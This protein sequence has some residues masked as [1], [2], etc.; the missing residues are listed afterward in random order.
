MS[1]VNT[2]AIPLP[3]VDFVERIEWSDYVYS[4]HSSHDFLPEATGIFLIPQSL[5]IKDRFVPEALSAVLRSNRNQ[6]GTFKDSLLPEMLGRSSLWKTLLNGKIH[7]SDDYEVLFD[8]HINRYLRLRKGY[9]E[10]ASATLDEA[11]PDIAKEFEHGIL[12]GQFRGYI[13][14]YVDKANVL[15]TV[16]TVAIQIVDSTILNKHH[17]RVVAGDYSGNSDTIH[18]GSDHPDYTRILVHEFRHRLSG[19]TFIKTDDP[20]E[21]EIVIRRTRIGFQE[22][23]RHRG[24]DEALVEHTTQA[25]IEGDWHTLDPRDRVNDNKVYFLERIFT[26]EFI[27][28]SGGLVSLKT[29]MR[30]NFED[31]SSTGGVKER[32]QMMR[33]CRSAY[34]PGALHKLDDLIEEAVKTAMKK[35]R[36]EVMKTFL[37]KIHAPEFD[38]QGNLVMQGWINNQF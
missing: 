6:D 12:Q 27:K 36:E 28:R 30:A 34:G 9:L 23:G 15:D 22:L 7:E 24:V 10:V 13:P 33:Q 19:G 20:W 8:P 16:D 32:R 35:P 17:G 5:D 3:I 31:T 1:D 14:D 2:P 26:A 37:Q 4:Q 18:I 38:K 25:I 11:Y 21:E 29:M